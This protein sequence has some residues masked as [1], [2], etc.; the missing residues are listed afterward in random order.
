MAFL[1]RTY[2][3]WLALVLVVVGFFLLAAGDITAAPILLVTGYCVLLP[4]FLWRS[5]RQKPGE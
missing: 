4:L 3:F 1:K 2:L 5:F